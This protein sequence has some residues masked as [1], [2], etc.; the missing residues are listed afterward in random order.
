MKT[1][2]N[3]ITREVYRQ[4][5]EDGLKKQTFLAKT[6][7]KE[8][9]IMCPDGRIIGSKHARVI[10]LYEQC[11]PLSFA[12]MPMPDEMIEKQWPEWLNIA[13]NMP[14]PL[15]VIQL[16]MRYRAIIGQ[17]DQM[18]LVHNGSCLELVYTPDYRP[19]QSTIGALYN[20]L[21]I[22]TMLRSMPGCNV[23][24]TLEFVQIPCTDPKLLT[25]YWGYRL[26][27][28]NRMCFA[29]GTL[30]QRNP[31]FN[32]ALFARQH[33]QLRQRYEQA[34]YRPSFAEQVSRLISQQFRKGD[35]AHP[36]LE[37]VCARLGMSRWTLQRRLADEQLTYSQ[38]YTRVRL[39]E[40]CQ[41]LQHS[42]W[43]VQ[44]VSERLHFS[45]PSAFA[46]FFREQLGLT[47]QQYRQR[48]LSFK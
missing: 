45:C 46:R 40:A 13:M 15:A 28:K 9:E 16:F 43:S 35:I 7:V 11:M 4:L 39:D 48:Q 1:V 14:S 25:E 44:E 33:Q 17:C 12:T 3:V 47:P 18:E 24:F 6:G 41:W 38:L 22:S 5:T 37:W 34:L 36:M 10:A 32:A 8:A 23:D 42:S 29:P 26:G 21:M 27:N 30:Q 31:L 2:A 19:E 20:F